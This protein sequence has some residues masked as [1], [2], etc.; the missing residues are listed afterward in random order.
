[1][2]PTRLGHGPAA[3]WKVCLV[4]AG[5][6]VSILAVPALAS[7]N[8]RHRFYVVG[9][10]V[11][12]DGH[13]VAS[14]EVSADLKS[15]E[16]AAP[17]GKCYRSSPQRDPCT[18][19]TSG[20]GDY[21][22]WWHQESDLRDGEVVVSVKGQSVTVKPDQDL[23]WAIAN[24]QLDRAIDHDPGNLQGWNASYRVR[25]RLWDAQ[26]DVVQQGTVDVTLALSD[27]GDLT[28]SVQT[29]RFG[30]FQ[31]EFSANRTFDSG[32][33]IVRA[34]GVERTFGIDGTY[35]ASY[36]GVVIPEPPFDPTS[37]LIVLVPVGL[38]LGGAGGYI[39]YRRL[40][41]RQEL[42]RA[43]EESDRKRANR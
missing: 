31:A 29:D 35:R 2:S 22:A 30:D 20:K 27:G 3:R 6:A 14:E 43:W 39:G 15:I 41:E 13:P 40:K 32:Q 21:V 1:M 37:L 11:D 34:E 18:V 24:L 26:G 5:F 28:R 4:A 9:R 17:E 8:Y 10:V 38:I 42:K 33:V 16:L 25:G 23:R 12:A 7:H 36:E 19:R